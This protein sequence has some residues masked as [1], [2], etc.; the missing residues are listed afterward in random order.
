MNNIYTLL[1]IF[2]VHIYVYE[3]VYKIKFGMIHTTAEGTYGSVQGR[4]EGYI[5]ILLFV[6]SSVFHFYN[7][8]ILLL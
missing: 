4:G 8:L 2:K 3:C 6:F 7:A 5:F 1:I